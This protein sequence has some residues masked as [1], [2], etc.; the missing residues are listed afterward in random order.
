[1]LQ[2]VRDAFHISGHLTFDAEGCI[3]QISLNRAHG[4]ACPF[5]AAFAISLARDGT[6]ANLRQLR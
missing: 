3:V 5:I 1:M 6:V 4:L 2:I